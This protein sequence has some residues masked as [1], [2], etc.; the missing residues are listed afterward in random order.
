[1]PTTRDHLPDA[2]KTILPWIIAGIACLI[3]SVL[4]ASF[5][6]TLQLSM[7]RGE[8]MR[9]ALALQETARS[10]ATTQLADARATQPTARP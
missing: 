9:E 2:L 1:M 4:L 8:A 6:D 7:R 10:N 3:A 5:I